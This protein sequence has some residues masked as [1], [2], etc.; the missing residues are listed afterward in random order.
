MTAPSPKPALEPLLTAKE[1]APLLGM[2]LWR[3]QRITKSG[4]IPHLRIGHRIR[5][6]PQDIREF[7]DRRRVAGKVVGIGGRDAE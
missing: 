1:A 3:L 7:L 2:G 4:E 5:Y 6:R